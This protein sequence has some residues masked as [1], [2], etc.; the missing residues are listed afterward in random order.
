M[1][2]GARHAAAAAARPASPPAVRFGRQP[3]R[4]EE[5]DASGVSA[6]WLTRAMGPAC[7]RRGA[8]RGR[9]ERGA[10]RVGP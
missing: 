3:K 9:W 4:K 2:G 8:T 10:V 6:L 5:D 1:L 7:Q